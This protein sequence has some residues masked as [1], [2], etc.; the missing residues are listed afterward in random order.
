MHALAW[1]AAAALAGALPV[2]VPLGHR[3][4][5]VD[6]RLAVRTTAQGASSPPLA[7]RTLAD[8]TLEGRARGPEY[9]ATVRLSPAPG[10]A[11]SLQIV[12]RWMAPARLEQAGVLLAWDGVPRAVG[13]DLSF[14]PLVRRR[15]S[16]RGTPVLV[17]AGPA[18]LAGG[19][20]IVAA[21]AEPARGGVQVELILDDADERP[22]STYETCRE[23]LPD[24]AESQQRSW[25]ELEVRH[26]VRG[27]PRE[28]GS[29]DLARANLYPLADGEPFLP[30]VVERWPAGARAAVVVTDHAD[31]TDPAA[32]RAVLWGSSDP[33]AEGGVGAGLLGRGLRIT[34]T[35]FVHARRG[36]LDDPEVRLLADDLAA[37][38]SEVALHSVT[39]ERDDRD[40]VRAGLAA[41]AAWRPRTWI[42]HQPYTNCEALSSRGAGTE[43][44]YGVRDLL[45]DAGLRW[46]WAAGDVDGSAGTRI[47]N[48]LGGDLGEARPA[49]FPLPGDA[50]LWV[51][52][53]SMFHAAPAELAAALSGAELA[54]LERERGLFVAHTY[55]GPSAR[56]T[57]SQD[58]LARLVVVGGERGVLAIH[59]ALDAA[60]ARLA[61]R[62]AAGRLASLAWAETGDRL[63]ALGDVE[64][65]YRPDGSA[66][67]RNHG[68]AALSGLTVSL[69]AAG[70]EIAAEGALLLGRDDEE[71]WARVWFDL[72]GGEK[73]VLRAWDALVPVP[74]LPFR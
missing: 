26:A 54:R 31:R 15:R 50:R 12:L 64:V 18:V 4:V 48:L 55:L 66:E 30:V 27:V 20:G 49:I 43:A 23:R 21:R 41:A 5:P 44:P 52:R 70:L 24:V 58:Q 8:G 63:R 38:G 37:A 67:V 59:P 7:W 39:P 28:P 3:V 11:R 65:L 47:V 72:A 17:A 46:I 10:G 2:E 71:G 6:V 22:F 33:R 40:A 42:D 32:L 74:L 56:T 29:V 14:E 53:S 16:G 25:A 13:R 45:A 51:F 73:V 69:P 34:R 1:L 61:A 19:P 68:A 9:E 57:Q 35:F 60:L 62:V 36:A